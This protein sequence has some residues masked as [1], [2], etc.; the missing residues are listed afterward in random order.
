MKKVKAHT[1]WIQV[2]TR[3]ITRKN[4]VGNGW[5]DQATKEAQSAAERLS[6]T[7]GVTAQMRRA[8]L[9]LKWAAKYT[10]EWTKDID[11]DEEDKDRRRK[12]RR[13]DGGGQEEGR[14]HGSLG[15]EVWQ[16]GEMAVCRRCEATWQAGSEGKGSYGQQCK[17][18]AAGRAAER[19]TGNINYRWGCFA[20]TSVSM[21]ESG[22]RLIAASAPPQCMVDEA[23]L[24]E[25]ADS[26]Q[27]DKVL[28]RMAGLLGEGRAWR[29]GTG[30]PMARRKRM[31][32][33][34]EGHGEA[35]GT[36]AASG[37]TVSQISAWRKSCAGR[38]GG[39]HWLRAPSWMAD[40][41][42]QPQEL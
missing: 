3:V 1:T 2:L 38:W 15:H 7:Q 13:R 36:I 17:G 21:V 25:V 18:S 16:K 28:R 20:K 32:R 41:M 29:K 6:P 22:A 14:L 31:S 42:V 8:V 19:A 10:A 40:S 12:E 5:A 39:L 26:A 35:P 27:Q 33:Q 23:K 4:H 9:W 11:A 37:P 30:T 34:E 24:D